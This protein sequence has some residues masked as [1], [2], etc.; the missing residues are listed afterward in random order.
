MWDAGALK[1]RCG[2]AR[3]LQFTEYPRTIVGRKLEV[4]M[5][6]FTVFPHKVPGKFIHDCLSSCC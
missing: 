2:M 5:Q 1:A 6:K 3:Y 4:G